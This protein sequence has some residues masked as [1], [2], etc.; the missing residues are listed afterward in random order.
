MVNGL[1]VLLVLLLTI[2]API[3]LTR[4]ILNL[5]GFSGK[6]IFEVGFMWLFYSLGI[7]TVIK[8]RRRGLEGA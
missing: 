2:Y 3:E 8:M 1:L 4:V 7:F 5:E 6:F